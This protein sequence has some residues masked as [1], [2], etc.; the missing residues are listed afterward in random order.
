MVLPH[1]SG[2][3]IPA[4]C[5]DE[6]PGAR[7]M[8]NYIGKGWSMPLF[9]MVRGDAGPIGE[10]VPLFELV[11]HDC[12][13]AGFS[14][15]GYATYNAGY[16]WWPDCTPR[17]YELMFCSAPAFNWL[18]HSDVPVQ[19]WDSTEAQARWAWLK[20]WS[21]YYRTIAMSQMTAHKFLSADH[22][23]QR[24][25]FANGVTAEFHMAKDL[26][27]VQGVD[28]FSGDWETPAGHLGDYPCLSK[29]IPGAS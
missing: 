17:L 19:D 20:R 25:E 16:D 6:L 29:D 24:I 3:L 9:G 26:C 12:Y 27:R 28:G 23:L 15:G 7:K 11:F 1:G 21:M 4:D 5:P 8:L 14:G 2:Y 18:P 22:Q 10:P 13:I